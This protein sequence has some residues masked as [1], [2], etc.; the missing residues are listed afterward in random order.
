MTTLYYFHDPM[1]SWCWGYRPSWQWL[2]E[3][4]PAGVGLKTVVGGLA[5]D[6]D[7][8]MPMEMQQNLQRIWR[9]ISKQLGTS[10]NFDFWTQCK[11]RR[12]T[13]PAC[14]AVIAADN[15]GLGEGMTLAIQQAY[16]QRAMNPSDVSTLMQL[17]GELS[18]D[19]ARFEAD[20]QSGDTEARLQQEVALAREWQV[21]GF[22][23]LV[24]EHQDRL[25]HLPVDYINPQKTLD[26]ILAYMA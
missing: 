1:C 25:H 21:P 6:S 19:V 9:R 7:V 14:R 10:F 15:Q 18:L 13:Y 16:Y 26:Q 3:R 2:Q 20:L 5:P 8:P 12:S 22:P 23:S 11:P 17:A 24:L 4:L